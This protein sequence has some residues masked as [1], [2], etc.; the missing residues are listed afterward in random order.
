[1]SVRV[2][3]NV[4]SW[5]V[6]P[7]RVEFATSADGTDRN[8]L[9]VATHAVPVTREGVMIH[10]WVRLRDEQFAVARPSASSL[11]DLRDLRVLRV[12]RDLRDLHDLRVH[13]RRPRSGTR[14][15]SLTLF[16]P[17]GQS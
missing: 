3:Q 1:M 17:L 6:L 4:R 10:P 9:G 16:W 8:S 15:A 12:L 5:I 2:L 13:A 7:A 11:R 14:R